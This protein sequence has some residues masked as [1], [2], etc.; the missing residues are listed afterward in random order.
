M[1]QR[2]IRL[3][4]FS[5]SCY[6][7]VAVACLTALLL[8]FGYLFFDRYSTYVEL[9]NGIRIAQSFMHDV[10]TNGFILGDQNGQFVLAAKNAEI[11]WQED[12]AFGMA[13]HVSSGKD[14]GEY[15]VYRRGWAKPHIFTHGADYRDY[16]NQHGLADSVDYDP[17]TLFQGVEYEDC[18]E[19]N[20]VRECRFRKL[21][22]YWMGMEEGKSPPYLCKM[23]NPAGRCHIYGKY[24]TYLSLA[25]ISKYRRSGMKWDEE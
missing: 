9:P 17:E 20:G 12:Y 10:G 22:Q 7:A 4:R 3:F 18:L 14:K 11:A 6:K 19:G 16:L 23:H 25:Q 21:D 2:L 1:K 24:K 13:G 15:F 5:W 8:L